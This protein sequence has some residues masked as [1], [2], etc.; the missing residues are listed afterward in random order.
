MGF[1]VE[2]HGTQGF[3]HLH[4]YFAELPGFTRST[5]ERDHALITP[6][7]RVWAGQPGW[8]VIFIARSSQ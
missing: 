5:Y 1:R 3:C 4:V 6:E 7:S 8:W 2:A